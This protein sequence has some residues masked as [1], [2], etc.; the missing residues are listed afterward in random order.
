MN[1]LTVKIPSSLELALAEASAQQ[2]LSKSE[3]VRRALEAYLRQRAAGSGFISALD[4][5]GD[6]VGCFAGGPRDLASNPKHLEGF[7][8]D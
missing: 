5:A 4:Q 1:T 7:G 6:L 3:L 2:H 8:R